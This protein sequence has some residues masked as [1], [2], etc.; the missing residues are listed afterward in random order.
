MSRSSFTCR[1][2]VAFAIVLLIGTLILLWAPMSGAEDSGGKFSLY[3][4]SSGG[5]TLPKDFRGKWTHLGTWALADSFHDVYTQPGSVEAFRRD[6]KFPDGTVLVKEIRK[7]ESGKKTTGQVSWAGAQIV[8]WFVM[9][10]DSKG[11]FPTNRIW[12]DG[13]G[14]ALYKA[15]APMVNI[16]KDYKID[17]IGCHIPAKG[18]DWVYVEGYPTLK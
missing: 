4:D 1:P 9:I 14:W 5:I 18:S 17:C 15:D 2:L 7:S 6:G 12:G 8:Q 10:K 3:V 13:W 16:A 11:R